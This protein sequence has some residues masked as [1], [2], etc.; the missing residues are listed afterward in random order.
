MPGSILVP[1]DGTDTSTRALPVALA[2][3]RTMRLPLEV[4]RVFEVAPDALT[5]RA[6]PPGVA[7][8]ATTLRADVRRDLEALAGSLR[9][10]ALP[11]TPTATVLEGVDVPGV[12][13]AHA[14]QRDAAMFVMTTVARGALGRALVG[15]VA[16]AVM[17]TA[18][19]PVVLVPP[20]GQGAEPPA[21]GR[22]RVVVLLDGSP[23]SFGAVEFLL[24][25]E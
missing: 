16:D 1:L 2:V 8:A 15:S 18:G 7:D 25:P 20:A 13:V 12:L 10:G 19:G 9:T 14:E 24:A 23:A 6:G 4:V 17:R 5:G 22:W 11:A 3:G 21:A